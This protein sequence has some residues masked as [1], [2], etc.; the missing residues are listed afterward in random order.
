MSKPRPDWHNPDWRRA[1][2]EQ[3]RAHTEVIG[4][5]VRDDFTFVGFRPTSGAHRAFWYDW[6]TKHD[7]VVTHWMFLPERP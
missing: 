2:E 1:D 4:Y 7:V 6:K 5:S 3:P